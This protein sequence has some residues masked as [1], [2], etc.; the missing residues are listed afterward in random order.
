MIIDIHTHTGNDVIRYTVSDISRSMKRYKIDY[1][2]VFPAKQNSPDK[3]VSESLKNMSAANKKLLPF[4]RFDPK[5]MKLDAFGALVSKFYGFK[6]HPRADN[7]NPL[8]KKFV[9]LFKA[10]E[11]EGKPVIVHS[12]KENNI[13]SDPDKV[14]KLAQKYPKINFIFGHFAND[15][16]YFFEEIKKYENA[17][18]ETSIVSSPKIIENRVKQIGADK[19]LFGSDAPYSDQ[20][21][22]L[23]KIKKC[24][25]SKKEKDLILYMNALKLLQLSEI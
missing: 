25:I 13:N 2:V 18:V 14:I 16:E 5:S 24:D 3:L 20:E 11:Q 9:R 21:I 1:S 22:E 6:L 19:I 23:L 8:D 15:S 17:F 12:R 10:I 4:L 7:F